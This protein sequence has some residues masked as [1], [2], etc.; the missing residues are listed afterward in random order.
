MYLL[1]VR[2][3][4]LRLQL[5]DYTYVSNSI[6]VAIARLS[7]DGGKPSEVIVLYLFFFFFD[8]ENNLLK[9]NVTSREKIIQTEENVK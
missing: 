6:F 5:E 2:C 1:F 9:L 8:E 7:G 3:W 4:V